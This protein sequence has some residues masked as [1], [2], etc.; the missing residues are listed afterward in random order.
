MVKVRVMTVVVVSS[1]DTIDKQGKLKQVVVTGARES[2]HPSSTRAAIASV[3]PQVSG[4][5]IDTG[6]MREMLNTIAS[7]RTVA[8]QA[9]CITLVHAPFSKRAM[10]PVA[11]CCS[12]NTR[13]SKLVETSKAS[14]KAASMMGRRSRRSSHAS[15]D[16]SIPPITF[17]SDANRAV[18]T[19]S[20]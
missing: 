15:I 18:V 3:D 12:P 11:P 1:G 9:L 20:M 17:G 10:P 5:G 13:R 14:F 4:D 6:T 7:G 16:P 2:K 8:K 19:G